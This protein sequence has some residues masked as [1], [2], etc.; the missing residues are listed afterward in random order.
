MTRMMN[1]YYALT[2][3]LEK[4]H[5]QFTESYV[6]TETKRNSNRSLNQFVSARHYD[7]GVGNAD[8]LWQS[9]RDTFGVQSLSNHKH[10][11]TIPAS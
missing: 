6:G 11:R 3:L 1:R 2:Q 4:T 9:S 10:V 8:W 7:C 5:S